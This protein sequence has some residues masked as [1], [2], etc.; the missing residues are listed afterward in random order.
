MHYF[1]T[2]HWMLSSVFLDHPG[3]KK[4]WALYQ[5]TEIFNWSKVSADNKL[6]QT[7]LNPFPNKPWFLHVCSRSLLKTLW[8]KEKLFITSNFSFS[9][10][11]FYPIGGLFSIFIKLGIVVCKLFQFASLKFVIWE[12]FK[13]I[14]KYRN[15]VTDGQR[16]KPMD[17]KCTNIHWSDVFDNYVPPT[18]SWLDKKIKQ[19]GQDGPG[20][21]TW[22]FEIVL[23]NFFFAFREEF[24][25]IS[26]CLYSA[27]SLH[28]LIPCLLTD[29]N[30]KN[31]SEK[32]HSRTFL[33]DYFK[34]WPIVSEKIFYDFVYVHI[35]K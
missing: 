11:V 32:G 3:K 29:Q 20:S 8:E 33:W 2:D 34:V 23:A 7:I 13:S 27:R 28:S 5:T 30:F 18:A 24:T 9:N 21:L 35:V 22:F 4:G 26:L 6:C 12:R 10:N 17:A 1:Y 15:S 14:Q 19:E 16:H 31:N 25:R